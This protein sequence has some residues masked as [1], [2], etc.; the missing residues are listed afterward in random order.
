[1]LLHLIE[2]RERVGFAVIKLRWGHR[3]YFGPGSR[4]SPQSFRYRGMGRVEL[5]AGVCIDPGNYPVSF[6]LGPAAAVEIGDGTWIQCLAGPARFA[7]AA[8]AEIKV[9]RGCWFTGGL[10]GSSGKITIGEGSIIGWGCSIIDSPL[11]DMDNDT[12]H[13]PAPISIG[14]YVWLANSVTVFPGVT[15]GDHCVIGTGS[16]V[17]SDIPPNSFAAGRPAKIVRSIGDRDRAR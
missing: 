10:L 15:I 3:V 1:L 7:A 2:L 8:G 6:D 13:K 14:S 17:M 5:G 9:G 16:L 11:H 4:V 12:P